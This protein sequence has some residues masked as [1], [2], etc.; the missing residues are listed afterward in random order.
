IPYFQPPGSETEPDT[1]RGLEFRLTERTGPTAPDAS[2]SEPI[3]LN[4]AATN[5]ML[6]RL[7]ALPDTTTAEFRFPP[8]SPPPRT[9]M[10]ITSG[11]PPDSI[12]QPPPAPEPAGPL[13]VVRVVPTGDTDLAP[14]VTVT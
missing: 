10:V 4:A 14:H 5:A 8:A 13:E 7:P 2:A 11:F 1:D 9:G 6:A 12:T 3:P